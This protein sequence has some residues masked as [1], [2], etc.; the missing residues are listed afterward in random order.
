MASTTIASFLL[1]KCLIRPVSDMGRKKISADFSQLEL[2]IGPIC[3]RMG[4]LGRSYQVLRAFKTV[5]LLSP[6]AISKSPVLGDP[7][8]YYLILHFLISNY[9][10]E[11]LRPPQK[12]MDW[13]VTRYIKWVENA[14]EEQRLTLI[15]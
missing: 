12:Y 8:P 15:K 2:A 14:S 10:P 4:D 11:E 5:L 1:H 7:V 3:E 13:S 9:A 6:E